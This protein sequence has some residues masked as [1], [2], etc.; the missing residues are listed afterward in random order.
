MNH[1]QGPDPGVAAPP[2][3]YLTESGDPRECER[4]N[5]QM[6]KES[7][8]PPPGRGMRPA[9][10]PPPPAPGL[11]DPPRR[12]NMSL[13][14]LIRG[15]ASVFKQQGNSRGVA[16]DAAWLTELEAGT[17]RVKGVPVVDLKIAAGKVVLVC[18]ESP[19]AMKLGHL[20]SNLE[21]LP[22]KLLNDEVCVEVRNELLPVHGAVLVAVSPLIRVP[23][24]FIFVLCRQPHIDMIMA[25]QQ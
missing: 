11:S 23:D 14:M 8:P 1:D 15:I 21:M 10:P 13:S 22:I 6:K 24:E 7:N 4:L 17:H 2:Y 18:R 12:E 3:I 20:F 25:G 9:P 19:V 5:E 16:F